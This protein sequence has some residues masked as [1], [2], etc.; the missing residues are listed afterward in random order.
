MA[1]ETQGD[2]GEMRGE[3][4]ELWECRYF[5]SGLPGFYSEK[6][7]ED[8]LAC[9]REPLPDE[10]DVYLLTGAPKI[11]AKIR[12]RTGLIKVKVLREREGDGFEK[13]STD[14]QMPLKTGSGHE[15]SDVLRYLGIDADG[16]SLAG[17][18]TVDEAIRALK[19]ARPRL[20]FVRVKKSRSVYRSREGRVE[21]CALTLGDKS[22]R[23]VAFE[24]QG[25]S[26]ARAIRTLFPVDS[27]GVPSN[28]VTLCQRYSDPAVTK[29]GPP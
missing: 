20:R 22:I 11:N 17:C 24:S 29:P 21:I 23:S 6:K 28:Y 19:R 7:L 13:W 2:P 9:T 16:K 27:L 1:E 3:P 26:R 4:A 15:W 18:K 14:F 8:V 25:L 10:E 5:V 12:T